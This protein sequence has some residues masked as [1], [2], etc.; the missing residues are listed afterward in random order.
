ME[1]E[2]T[3]GQRAYTAYYESM[4]GKTFD[5]RPMPMWPDLPARVRI[6]WE[7]AGGQV[8][9]DTLRETIA[10]LQTFQDEAGI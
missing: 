4:R 1:T 10:I 6:G 8:H 5:G 9:R 2:R 3:H 7:A